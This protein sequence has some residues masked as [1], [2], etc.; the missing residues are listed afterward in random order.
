M[1][2]CQDYFLAGV[3]ED[4]CEKCK[5][6][7]ALGTLLPPCLTEQKCAITKRPK[8]FLNLSE[9]ILF[10]QFIIYLMTDDFPPEMSTEDKE[11][12]MQLKV[13]TTDYIKRMRTRLK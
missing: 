11:I 5:K 6:G 12:A 7:Y 3:T 1:T 13:I 2:A 4:R 8:T 9:Q 10:D